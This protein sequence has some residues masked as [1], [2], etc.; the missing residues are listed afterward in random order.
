MTHRHDPRL[1]GR[2]P[3][4]ARMSLRP[5]GIGL[6]AMHDVADTWIR[7]G[8][9]VREADVPSALRHGSKL[10][11]LDQYMRRNLRKMVGRH[12]NTPKEVLLKQ[13]IEL[14]PL[15]EAADAHK[16]SLKKEVIE[17][18][19]GRVEGMLKRAEIFKQGKKL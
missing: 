10:L 5:Y 19:K 3:E 8:L 6:G 4:F 12:E 13:E 18:Q 11:P 1:N 7:L 16:V 17:Q 2:E 15:R 14:Q 9:D